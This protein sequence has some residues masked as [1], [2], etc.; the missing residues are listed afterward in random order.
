MKHGP[1][2]AA[3]GVDSG[4]VVPREDIP[5]TGDQLV[6]WR[7]A[8]QAAGIR[9]SQRHRSSQRI[10]NETDDAALLAESMAGGFAAATKFSGA[11]NG[12]VFKTGEQGLGYYK[13]ESSRPAGNQ[14]QV[15][16]LEALI[17]CDSKLFPESQT[18]PFSIGAGA[19][20]RRARYPDGRRKRWLSRHQRALQVAQQKGVGVQCKSTGQLGEADWRSQGWWAVDCANPNSWATAGETLLPRSTADVLLIQET[21]IFIP[22]RIQAAERR[23][24]ATGWSPVFTP[25]HALPSSNLGSGGCA[26]LRARG[27]GICST[28]QGA[29]SKQYAHRICMAWVDGVLKGGM[30][31]ASVYLRTSEGLTA[32]NMA[33]LEEL[34]VALKVVKGPWVV[35]G[36]WNISPEVLAASRWPEMVGGKIFAGSHP[37][38]NNS[39]YD[40]FV[41][42]RAV[43]HAVVGVQRLDD[44]GFSPHWAT[45]LFIKGDARRH[46]VRKLCKPPL[47]KGVLPQGPAAQPPSYDV[48]HQLSATSSGAQQAMMQWYRNARQEW[49]SLAGQNLHFQPFK[50]RWESPCGQLAMP[51]AG[52][53]PASVMW[54][55]L[56][57]RA[58]ETSA[59][60]QAGLASLRPSQAKLFVEHIAKVAG[61]DSKLSN[62]QGAQHRPAVC[63]WVR[64]FLFAVGSNSCTWLSS[65]QRVADAKARKLEEATT[66][67]RLQKWRV[68]IGAVVNI[69]G[70]AKIPTR[71]AYR[72]AKGL[73]GWQQSPIG[74]SDS[75]DWVPNIGS[76]ENP[77]A[78]EQYLDEAFASNPA[79]QH[80]EVQTPLCDQAVVEAEA[81]KWGQLWQENRSYTLGGSQCDLAALQLLS[82][83]AIK[84]AASSFPV[85][86]G[87]GVDNI[88]PRAFLRLSDAALVAL[89]TLFACFEASGCWTQALD[90]VIIV[91]LPKPDGGFRP[92]GLFPTIIRLWMRAR[93]GIARAWES[94]HQI[95]SLFGGAG[96]GAQRAAWQAA[97]AAEL[98]VLGNHHHVQAMI[99]LVKAFETVP[100]RQL[101]AAAHAKGYDLRIL[102]MSLA[103]YRLQRTVGID[104]AYSRLVKATRG[105]TAG[106][107]F[108]TSELRLLLLDMM[109]ELQRRWE[110]ALSAML[111]VD[112]LNLSAGGRQSEIVDL[113]QQAV[114]FVTKVLERD[115]QL[116]IS[117]KKSV[118]VASRPMLAAAT[119]SKLPKLTAVRRAKLLG[120]CAAGGRR[121]ST[122]TLR[123][124]MQ[125][126]SKSAKRF[127][128]LRKAG[129][130]TRLMVRAAGTPALMY[131][132]EVM[133]AADST[134]QV[135][136]SKVAAA[137]APQAGGKNPDMTLH[138]LDG[139]SGTLDPAFDAHVGLLRHWAC[140]W[141]EG[142]VSKADLEAAFQAGSLKLATCKTTLWSKVTGPVTAL[143]ASMHRIGWALPSASEIV[144]DRGNSWSFLLDS[145]AAISSAC[146]L[147]V[148]RWRLA[149]IGRVLP[150]LI[151]DGVDVGPGSI[152]ECPTGTVL[153]DFAATTSQ[154]FKLRHTVNEESY[155]WAPSWRG[156]LASAMS[157]GQWPQARKA[158]V[159]SWG[160]DDSNC[161][162][163]HAAVGTLEH[164][165]ACSATCPEAGWIPPPP[166]AAFVRNRLGVERLS[167][168]TNRGM[169]VLR[170][171]ALPR[172]EEWFEWLRDPT[173]DVDSNPIEMTWY[174]DGSLLDGEWVD[175]RATGFGIVVAAQDGSIVGYGRGCPPSWCSTA[176]AAETWALATALQLS[177]F[178]PQLRTDC[179]ALLAVAEGGMQKAT[180]ADKH[181]ARAW[182]LIAHFLDGDTASLS[183]E[184]RLVWMPAHQSVAAI[185]EKRLSNGRVLSTVDWRA[186]RLAD[187]L[188]KQAAASRQGK[189]DVLRMLHSGKVAVRHAAALLGQVTHASNNHRVVTLAADG[190]QHVTILRDSQSRAPGRQMQGASCSTAT[191]LAGVTAPEPPLQF[192]ADIL[193]RVTAPEPT[194]R[195][196]AADRTRVEVAKRR[197]LQEQAL[198]Q[199]RV[200]EVAAHSTQPAT[201]ATERMAGVRQRVLSRLA[202][203]PV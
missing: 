81:D 201:S 29:V 71:L 89:A 118:V 185:G 151:P 197:R 5:F 141:W 51:Q 192:A 67:A 115:L 48:V 106:S 111:Y 92:I 7:R 17:Q 77:E 25:A 112:D 154:L 32:A 45:R 44:G 159:R 13:E 94:L 2:V 119:A 184:G 21:R 97:F 57:R 72:W 23:S 144:D 203:R 166:E 199:R 155:T 56:A 18:A 50:F 165:F 107:G 105:I 9:P 87:L 11:V 38:C 14:P 145:P 60:L 181:L 150:F 41:V 137:A 176:A 133:G 148:R 82:P 100:H 158:A 39:N 96:M 132:I 36:D 139:D 149:R 168:L 78:C 161:Q 42:D 68:A 93:I 54:R 180:G 59:F 58:N 109:M 104:G 80:M 128:L 177:A 108:A 84:L 79:A 88:A 123:V 130:N 69:E 113:M 40:F 75:N 195:K 27:G 74:S 73:A 63:A 55:T 95:P 37:T 178:P 10:G 110:P 162:L 1:T 160:I 152:Q 34:A 175:F 35:G 28:N 187:A 200:E 143:L 12:C 135:V 171:P 30:H 66:R 33:I 22:D 90:L 43:A 16:Q 47:V 170:L 146:R 190:S 169:L 193:A 85:G 46:A 136:R 76:E 8:E 163:C 31:F 125:T 26:V 116:E 99:D 147:A 189:L 117:A 156:A 153:V 127:H 142:W 121:R 183:R 124:R 24:R 191:R 101:L 167:T 202:A 186:N 164:R 198:L 131:G 103:A 52:S 172:R 15:I 194:K 3:L 98:S 6:E 157:G 134:L 140:A 196:A 86:T 64:S 83:W 65:L 4:E 49:S 129:V 188:A 102:L 179:Q 91:L 70:A 126:F 53:T 20:A 122:R 120:T 173:L 182:R 61:A 62:T 114:H 138:T 174:L 19:R